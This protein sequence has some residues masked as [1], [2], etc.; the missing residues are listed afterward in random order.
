[1]VISIKEMKKNLPKKDWI[2]EIIFRMREGEIW[3]HSTFV[4]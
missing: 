2:K 3:Q 4:T 1:M